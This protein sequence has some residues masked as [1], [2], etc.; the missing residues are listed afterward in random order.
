MPGACVHSI[1]ISG[2]GVPKL[3]VPRARVTKKGVEGDR[4][5]NRIYH[6]GPR[7]AVCIFSLELIRILQKEGHPIA[8]GTIGENITISGL[9]WSTLAEGTVLRIGREVVLRITGPAKPC[10]N[11]APSFCDGDS[12]RVSHRKHPG[13]NRWYARVLQAGEIAPG[14]AVVVES[15]APPGWLERVRS[16]I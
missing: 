4:Q 16:R 2:G 11:I 13:E 7:R 1:Q 5:R 3:P 14:D 8:P 9:D 15:T 6:G 10:G 12:M